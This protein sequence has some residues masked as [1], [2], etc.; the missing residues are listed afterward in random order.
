MKKDK[1]D[2][3]RVSN[4][5]SVSKSAGFMTRILKPGEFLITGRI[6]A[7]SES[8]LCCKIKNTSK[9]RRCVMQMIEHRWFDNTIMT[10]I[11]LNSVLMALFDYD[12]DNRCA[13]KFKTSSCLIDN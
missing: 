3:A 10:C 11:V 6:L 12:T 8:S 5:S 4:L 7:R 9:V 13:N 2:K 1:R